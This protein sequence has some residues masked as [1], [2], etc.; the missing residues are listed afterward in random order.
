MQQRY[1][2]FQAY[3][4]EGILL[5]CKFALL[6]LLKYNNTNSFCVILYTDNHAFFKD[7]LQQFIHHQIVPLTPGKIKEWRG[8]INFV[9]RI[10]IAMLL[11]F[12]ETHNGAV[13]YFDTDTYC[14]ASIISLFEAI[15]KGNIY[16]H[17][18]EGNLDD[19]K[20]IVFKKWK[21]FLKENKIACNGK[22]VANI[23][24][25]QMWN[26]GVL[27][28]SGTYLPQL[29]QVLQLTDSIYP[30]FPKHTVEQFAFSYI[31]QNTISIKAADNFIYHYWDL[32]E[33]KKLLK[34][35]VDKNASLSLMQQLQEL[36]AALPETIFN[37]KQQYKKIPFFKKI[38]FKKW[39]IKN[40]YS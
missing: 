36:S 5:E 11:H 23:D 14:R 4:N 40:Y 29:K 24:A 1:I 26:A 21:H 35:L 31:F 6:Q 10:K 27:G 3:G 28:F 32:K 16:M 34:Y 37:E 7:V 13:L 2:L 17:T 12:F 20:S 22:A 25:I 15:E 39:D 8:E 38:F 19:R 33:Y 30:I 9:H 18:Y